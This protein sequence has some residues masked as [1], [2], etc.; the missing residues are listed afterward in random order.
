MAFLAPAR[1]RPILLAAV[2]CLI[3][4]A[5]AAAR[6]QAR[7]AGT[8][9]EANVKAVFLYNFSKYVTWP[10]FAVGERSPAEVRICATADD[11][12]YALLRAAVEGE[13]IDGKPLVAVALDGL[14]EAKSCQ[15]LY[16]GDAR[17]P[18]GR[19]W[20][21]AVRGLQVRRPHRRDGDRV[22]ARRQSRPLR[23]QPRRRRAP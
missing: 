12:F 1:R 21:S 14:D 9:I 19:A 6:A 11:G 7:A 5:S 23:H 22:C 13:Y 17:S 20:L 18:D 15:I 16:V 4:G 8:P 10:A 3:A 2:V